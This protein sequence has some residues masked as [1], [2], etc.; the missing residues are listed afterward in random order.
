[1]KIKEAQAAR[2]AELERKLREVEAQ[3]VHTHHFASKELEKFNTDRLA[4]SA[5]VV[6]L[7]ALGG[8]LTTGPFAI[9]GGLSQATITALQA[10]LVRSYQDAVALK[11]KGVA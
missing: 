8:T 11:P 9:R 1:M 2:I 4:A 10:D 7:T 5:V 6:T 3:L